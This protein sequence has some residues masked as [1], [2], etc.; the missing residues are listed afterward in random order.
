MPDPDRLLA[1]SEEI[2]ATADS[3]ILDR[4]M[5]WL[6]LAR[7]VIENSIEDPWLVDLGRPGTP[8]LGSPPRDSE[9]LV[10]PTWRLD[11]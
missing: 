9:E 8:T 3:G 4:D 10:Y 11:P 5:R 6:D 7:L 2:I 1:A